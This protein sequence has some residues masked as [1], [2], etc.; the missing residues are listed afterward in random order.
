VSTVSGRTHSP[1]PL[2]RPRGL[3][4][5]GV[6]AAALPIAIGALVPAAAVQRSERPTLL[7]LIVV[8]QMRADYLSRFGAR[9]TGGL[10]RL[11]DDGAVYEQAYYPYLNTVTCAGHATLGTGAWPKSHGIIMNQWY[12]RQLAAARTCTADPSVTTYT[13]GGTANSGGHSA[14]ALRMPTLAERLARRWPQSR[15]VT[16]SLKPR[17]AIMM[18]GRTATSV[19]WWGGNGWQSSTA[20]GGPRPE[21]A[22]FIEG[23][24]V[25][26]DREST[27]ERML[28][29][30]AY[31]G[32]DAGVG[33][34]PPTGWS[35]LF[36]HAL[37]AE[38]ERRF[39]ALWEES[40]FSD[41]YL[42]AMA[43]AAVRDFKL[44]QRGVVD[45]LGVSFS[46][47]DLVGHSFGPDSHEVQD[48]LARLD[49]TL[50][51]LLEILD[52]D[53]GRRRYVLA[54]SADHGVATV[55]E[56]GQASATSRRVPLGLVRA[57]VER[58]LAPLGAGP[59]VARVEY[60]QVYLT[61]GSR[62][63]LTAETAAPAIAALR[64]IPGVGAALWVGAI[65]SPDPTISPALMDAI[66]ASHVPDRSGDLVVVPAPQS[67]FIVGS[68]PDG[69]DGTTHGSP[70][71][72][73][74]HVPVVFLG[75]SF[76]PGRYAERVTPADV[77]PTLAA[78]IGMPVTGVEGRVLSVRR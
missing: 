47:N 78:T 13:Y 62:T 37:A 67:I 77:A 60:T 40:P 51:R 39:V 57:T 50:G 33:E 15:A 24:P 58:A 41:A 55:P 38:D 61:P 11:L 53:V 20:F 76:A 25:A 28:P 31:S 72:Y 66:R 45:F 22:A 48:V 8:D 3:W 19:T 54:L 42:G 56:A 12:D 44:G 71:E 7:V 10:R 35:A 52:R 29:D 43:G 21:I 23:H 34:R 18:A 74:Q 17:S 68:N 32:T 2:R 14:A 36:P 49:Q 26:A 9:W 70:H 64:A 16:L 1:R 73:D 27:W 69:G 46:A 30:A 6:A 63:R 5:L 59:H 4:R 75:P 65:Q